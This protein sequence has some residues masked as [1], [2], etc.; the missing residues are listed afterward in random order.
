MWV[1]PCVVLRLGYTMVRSLILDK[2][3]ASG[4]ILHNVLNHGMF[5]MPIKQE[6]TFM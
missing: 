6:I 1:T 5:G 2:L 3:E 4:I